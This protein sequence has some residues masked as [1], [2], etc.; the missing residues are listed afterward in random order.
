MEGGER[1]IGKQPVLVLRVL[2]SQGQGQLQGVAA[3]ASSRYG[4]RRSVEGDSHGASVG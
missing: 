4:K 3:D 1:L 2:G